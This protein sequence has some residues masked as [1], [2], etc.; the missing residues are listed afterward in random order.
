VQGYPSS[1]VTPATRYAPVTDP[2]NPNDPGLR[3][4][5]GDHIYDS[6]D[7]NFTTTFEVF[8]PAAVPGDP[9]SAPATPLCTKSYS[10]VSGDLAAALQST[11]KQNVYVNG[12]LT[13]EYLGQ[14]F[15][16]WDNLCPAPARSAPRRPTTSSRCGP[17]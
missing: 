1:S 6:S 12:V 8:G 15:R 3:Y 17:T 7:F 10:T 14:Y 11:T 16:Q 5:T 13:P 4:C 9:T 2:N